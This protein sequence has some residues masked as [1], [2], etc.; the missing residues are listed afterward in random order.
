[1][2]KGAGRLSAK[3]RIIALTTDNA[4]EALFL[5]G[6]EGNAIC[7]QLFF[8]S[9]A[10][11]ISRVLDINGFNVLLFDIETQRVT[12]T[13]LADLMG[14]YKLHV[15][16]FGGSHFSNFLKLGIT[17][18]MRK[19]PEGFTASINIFTKSLISKIET[20]IKSGGRTPAA[21]A[22]GVGA[23]TTY[24]EPHHAAPS[25]TAQSSTV[26]ERQRIIAMTASTGGTEALVEVLKNLPANVP[27]ILIV[28]HM[29]AGFTKQFAERLDRLCQFKVKEAE[30]GDYLHKSLALL[31]PGNYHMRL[32]RKSGALAVENV[33]TPHV[34]AVRPAA[35][36]LFQS[37]TPI[38]G[39]NV[40]GVIL[41]GMGSDGARGLFELKAK[42]AVV[43]GQDEKTCAVYG[44]PK[45]AFDIGAVDYQVPLDRVAS[46]MIKLM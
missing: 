5:N 4:L 39:G 26:T 30:T 8:V 1:V 43:I 7:E 29:P 25:F 11:Q 44:M 37:I 40:L 27:P 9:G 2:Q 18:I 17:E 38:M 33:Q 19:P 34:H 42:G 41:T 10:A 28:Q 22:Y 21:P 45:A 46:M 23:A 14:R 3:A 20:F 6:L 12:D 13:F 31:A 16:L 35:D 24:R 36:V 15:I 32:I